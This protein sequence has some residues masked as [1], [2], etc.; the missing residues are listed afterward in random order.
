MTDTILHAAGAAPVRDVAVDDDRTAPDATPTP[1]PLRTVSVVAGIAGMAALGLV[2]ALG[3][4]EVAHPSA[5]V[6]AL[7][8]VAVGTAAISLPTL[9]VAS[10]AL[11]LPW[12]GEV[13]VTALGAGID[14]AGRVAWA[15]IPLAIFAAITTDLG[16][17]V[18]LALATCVGASAV[19]SMRR[20]LAAADVGWRVRLAS[21]AW[22]AFATLVALR[23]AWTAAKVVT[24][25]DA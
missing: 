5:L 8:L 12:S 15:A 2:G 18:F 16:P 11:Q 10:P 4:A 9:I 23:L 25:V 3:D 1:S 24:G 14:R 13:V 7:P 19:R 17:L 20:G 21:W 22:G 6:V